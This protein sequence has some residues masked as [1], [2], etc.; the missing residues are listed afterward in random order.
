MP[1]YD[2]ELHKKVAKFIDKQPPKL[3]IRIASALEK[4]QENPYREDFDIKKLKNLDQ[5][6]RL[7]IGK[8][9]FLYTIFENRLLIYMYKADSRGDV[10]K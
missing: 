8:F 9:R 7:R 4:L 10:Y 6:Y 1:T 2:L 5:D 3:K